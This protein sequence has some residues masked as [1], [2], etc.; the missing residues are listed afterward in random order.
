MWIDSTHNRPVVGSS[1]T[2]PTKISVYA[3]MMVDN[4]TRGKIINISSQAG[5]SVGFTLLC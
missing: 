3:Q 2:W 5:R 4:K 1:P